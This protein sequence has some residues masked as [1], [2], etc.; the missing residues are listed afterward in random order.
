MSHTK[1]ITIPDIGI[2]CGI[3][4]VL[5]S[6]F[7][8]IR[9]TGSAERDV[10]WDY[11]DIENLHP[12]FISSLAI[13]KDSIKDVVREIN[14]GNHLKNIFCDIAFSSPLEF[15]GDTPPEEILQSFTESYQ[16]PVCKFDRKYQ[17]IDELQSAL[18]AILAKQIRLRTDGWTAHTPVSYLIS[19]LT[20]NIQEHS[21]GSHGF[22]TMQCPEDEDAISICIADN[23]ITV[24]GSYMQSGKTELIHMIGSD[25]VEALRYATKGFSTK[26]RPENESRGYGISTNLDMV[27]NGLGGSFF[28]LSGKAFFRSDEQGEQFVNLPDGMY[29][30]GTIILVKIPL[31]QKRGFNV[32]NYIE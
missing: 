28:M 32:Y 10:V 21:H 23:G 9:E 25:H 31:K 18:F 2:N 3:G 1:V 16:T 15:T 29:W 14:V 5:M 7:S 24:Y 17:R 11:N 19:E 26:N 22:M 20:C 6:L 13:Y 27:V 4:E 8:V 12:F 30:D